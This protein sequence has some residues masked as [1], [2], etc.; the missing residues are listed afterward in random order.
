MLLR[1]K[2]QM[3]MVETVVAAAASSQFPFDYMVNIGEDIQ[4]ADVMIF[5]ISVLS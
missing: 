4:E 3:A 2:V 1:R 5:N